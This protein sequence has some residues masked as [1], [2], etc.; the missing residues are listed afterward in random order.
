MPSFLSLSRLWTAAL[1]FS[2]FVH[3]QE[4][5]ST[6]PAAYGADTETPF[7]T[8]VSAPDLKPPQLLITK[9]EGQ[10]TDG[11]LFIGVDGEPDS[12]QNVPCIFGQI[13]NPL[14]HT[15]GQHD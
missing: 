4:A 2:S 1:L 5:P 11:Y 3:S 9:N 10:L 14:L 15:M 8:Y 13:Q 12:M 7:Q 6:D